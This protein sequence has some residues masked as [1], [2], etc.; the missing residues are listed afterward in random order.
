MPRSSIHPEQPFILT[1]PQFGSA[2]AWLADRD[3]SPF[4]IASLFGVDRNIDRHYVS[5]LI[6][7]A[8]LRSR[9]KSAPPQIE[10]LPFHSAIN[11]PLTHEERR[12]TQ[13]RREA[14]KPD[15]IRSQMEEIVTRNSQG[16]T[17]LQ[18]VA[19]LNALRPYLGDPRNEA[20]LRLLAKLEC[21]RAW[22]FTHAGWSRSSIE[23]AGQAYLTAVEL[24][25]RTRA[26][27]ELQVI[28]DAALIASNAHLNRF[29]P[30]E[31]RRAL[32]LATA[33]R[34][35]QSEYLNEE[36][37]RQLAVTYLQEAGDHDEDARQ[38]FKQAF[39]VMREYGR[40]EDD[41][42]ILLST[43]RQ[44]NLL[45][46]VNWDGKDGA[47]ELFES[48][49]RQFPEHSNEFNIAVS[50]TAACGFATDSAPANLTAQELIE[51]HSVYA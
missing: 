8:K 21:H 45:P 30:E 23:A 18:G 49:S 11:W 43:Q 28:A 25:R 35:S 24:Y 12:L 15:E 38:S 26:C 5:V 14:L 22:F 6:H 17:F 10:A 3:I 41:A 32:R 29:E 40:N 13:I 34:D 16:Y 1:L 9:R 27:D 4:C 50:W 42:S 39:A 20:L 48:V 51:D 47:L 19:E 33:A 7:R 37:H 44:A 36:Y 46:P 2:M 31:A